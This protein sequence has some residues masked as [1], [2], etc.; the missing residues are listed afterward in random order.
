[1]KSIVRTFAYCSGIDKDIEAAVQSCSK[2]AAPSSPKHL[3]FSGPANGLSNLFVVG[4]HS[5]CLKFIPLKST[6]TT[7]SINSRRHIFSNLGLSATIVTINNTYFSPAFFQD[8]CR[9]HNITQICSQS[10][11]QMELA[12][13]AGTSGATWGRDNRRDFRCVSFNTKMT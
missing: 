5:K 9:C 8:F 11:G 7:M 4:T 2:T 12:S 1:M 13:E 6:T 3:N 10:N